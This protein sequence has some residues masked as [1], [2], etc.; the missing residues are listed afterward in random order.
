MAPERTAGAEM[1]APDETVS[2]QAVPSRSSVG[3]VEEEPLMPR[4]RQDTLKGP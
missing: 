3:Q 2:V 4:Q 1:E